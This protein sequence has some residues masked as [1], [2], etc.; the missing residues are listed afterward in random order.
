VSHEAS[1]AGS[2]KAGL[3]RADDYRMSA[4][5]SRRLVRLDRSR[6]GPSPQPAGYTTSETVVLLV[7]GVAFMG[8]LIHTGAAV[9][10]FGEFP[11]YTL[12][13]GVLATVQIA[14]AA[15][16]LWRPSRRVLLF[17]CAFNIGVIGLWVASRTV[18]VPIAPRAW[19][20]E[21]VGV[22]DLVETVGEVVTVIAALSVAMSPSL[23][24]AR[25]MTER[26]AP[27][28]LTILFLS[29]LYGVGAHA[30]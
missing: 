11:L 30:G 4:I 22:A 17:G 27:M 8:G 26:I 7:A 9:D 10:H 15:M 24:V 14:W 29:A 5:G 3:D 13:F 23:L 1:Q 25:Y 6:P 28:L 19:V 18:G 21:A 20:P 16:I 2:V 12:V